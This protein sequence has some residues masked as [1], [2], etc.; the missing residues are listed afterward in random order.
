MEP[1]DQDRDGLDPDV[2]SMYTIN[3]TKRENKTISFYHYAVFAW[4]WF[5]VQVNS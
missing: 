4:F 1:L 2:K 5:S 3:S